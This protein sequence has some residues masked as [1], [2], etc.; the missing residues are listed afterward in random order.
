[1]SR[2]LST[3]LPSQVTAT[4]ALDLFQEVPAVSETEVIEDSLSISSLNN[5]VT[6]NPHLIAPPDYIY[7]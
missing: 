1:M 7:F 4:R 6:Q 5:T 2:R 3:K